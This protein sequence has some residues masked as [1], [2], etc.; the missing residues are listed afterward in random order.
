MARP[1]M[2][3]RKIRE[4]L[5]QK[6]S[7]GRTHREVATSLRVSVG[8]ITETLTRAGVAGLDWSTVTEL[9]DG[10][11]ERRLYGERTRGSG[12]RPRPDCHWIHS[13][14]RKKGVTLSLLNLEY[15]ERNPGGYRYTQFC[16]IYRSWLKKR[17]LSMRQVHR[18]G[19]KMFVDYAG[20]KPSYVD[21]STGE[22]IEVELFVAVL[23]ASNYTFAEATRTQKGPD[24]IGSHQ[25]AFRF[26]G[27]VTNAT[28]CDQLKSGVVIPC[29]Y[30]PGV[31]HTYE[32][33][34]EHYGTAIVPA[35]PRSPKDKAKVEAAVQV[36][37][38]WILARLRNETFFSLEELNERI[39]ELLEELNHRVMRVYRASRREL[40]ERLDRPALK[41]LPERSFVFGTWKSAKVSIDYH[42]AVEGHYYSAPHHLVGEKVDVRVSSTT[43]E[44]YLR[45]QRVTSHR[46][47]LKRGGHTT[48]PEHMPVSHRKHLEWSPSRFIRW[49]K[50]IGPAT[51]NLIEAI[52]TD[53]PHP[54]QGYRS[55]L[56][57]L[58]LEKHY[59]K[60]RL[61]AACAR[62]FAVGARSYRH[63]DSVLKHGLDRL[64][65]FDLETPSAPLE[66]E[67]IRG[68][69]YYQ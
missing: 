64:P 49:G 63:V 44:I 57:I 27:G 66:H 26:F 51:A 36:A 15:L 16:E 54:E 43:V 33:L 34:A 32:E 69:Q 13:E 37:E 53:R 61:E 20:A 31:Q 1:R 5:R 14:L 59:G 52:L 39:A 42:V 29:R 17:R 62:A 35:R 38:R 45:R 68:A 22:L 50:K 55:C 47:S 30:E 11:L 23:G 67:N 12:N 46:R 8:T 9:D 25:R 10:E 21:R 58:R 6:W 24:W 60:E 65:A 18:A 3:M 41:P 40:F 7:L 2:G 28:V 48:R 19:E 4:I 56:G